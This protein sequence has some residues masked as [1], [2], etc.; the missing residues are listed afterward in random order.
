K[1]YI[2]ET[3]GTVM[4]MLRGA[5]AGR[6]MY[7]S[8]AKAIRCSRAEATDRPPRERPETEIDHPF[9]V[10]AAGTCRID[11]PI[12]GDEKY[13]WHSGEFR[14]AA[15]DRE[16]DPE[17][18]PSSVNHSKTVRPSVRHGG[19]DR[20]RRCRSGRHPGEVATS[21]ARR[22]ASRRGGRRTRCRRRPDRWCRRAPCPRRRCRWASS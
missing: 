18:S 14:R 12:H 11:T 10:T 13:P 21:P 5:Q 2:R 3:L 8:K 19:A 17:I 15:K 4:S 7:V 20:G 22:P 6:S 9:P 16:K 1:S